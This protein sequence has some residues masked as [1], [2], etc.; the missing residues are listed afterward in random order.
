MRRVEAVVQ[1]GPVETKYVRAG[2]GAPVLLLLDERAVTAVVSQLLEALTAEFR[3]LLPAIDGDLVLNAPDG[4]AAFC[5]WLRDF[6]DGLGVDRFALIATA[7]YSAAVAAFMSTDPER[8]DRVVLLGAGGAPVM[9]AAGDR[10]ELRLDLDGVGAVD[11]VPALVEFLRPVG[12]AA[13]A[14]SR[15]D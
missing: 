10:R 4:H 6:M 1:T 14:R 8:I 7:H 11:A 12:V 3:L 9:L 2:K 15:A 5:S 13:E